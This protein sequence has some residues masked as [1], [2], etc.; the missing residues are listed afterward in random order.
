MSSCTG[1]KLGVH[2]NVE[3]E[4]ERREKREERGKTNRR[5]MSGPIGSDMYLLM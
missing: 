5:E 4:R 2:F 1:G 3:V